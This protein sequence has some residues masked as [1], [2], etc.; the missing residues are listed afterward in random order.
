[1]NTDRRN[2][3][4]RGGRRMLRVEPLEARLPMA[5]DVG[6]FV[7]DGNLR[8]VGDSAAN[9]ISIVQ[10]AVG[11]FS[12][13]G[14][15]GESFR[16]DDNPVTGPVT[17]SG[18]TKTITMQLGRGSDAVSVSG[19]ADMVT[20]SRLFVFSGP[21]ADRVS[22]S[23]ARIDGQ[24]SIS[25]GNGDSNADGDIVSITDVS[26]AGPLIV[27]TGAGN[28]SVT[29][30]GVT[31]RR[32]GVNTSVGQDTVSIAANSAVSF[33]SLLISLGFGIDSLTVGT[34][35]LTL[36]KGRSRFVGGPGDDSFSGRENLAQGSL[37]R[38][39]VDGFEVVS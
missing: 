33:D 38:L 15:G 4:R 9:D 8:I 11:E 20:A 25:T 6:L 16:L 1:M 31:A 3:V 26:V 23:S 32:A 14:N 2:T 28:D 39:A 37:D 13:I 36:S 35:T 34:G 29:I 19:L 10:T 7:S 24:L 18:V 22:V 30:D 5:G 12:I 17:V 27:E 21:G